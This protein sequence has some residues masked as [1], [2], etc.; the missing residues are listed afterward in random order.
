[1]PAI[2]LVAGFLL[3]TPYALLDMGTFLN[4]LRIQYGAQY[5]GHI[6]M[7]RAGATALRMLFDMATKEGPG[8]I[9]MGLIGIG[10][11]WVRFRRAWWVVVPLLVVYLLE[12]S[13]WRVYADRY[14][15]PSLPLM[16]VLASLA[17]DAIVGRI[18]IRPVRFLVATVLLALV[19]VP[20]AVVS[21]KQASELTLPDTRTLALQ[22][23]EQNIP[24]SSAILLELGGPQPADKN[25]PHHREPAYGI[26][27]LPPRFSDAS[28]GLDPSTALEL[29]EPEYVITS[30]NY[31]ARYEDSYTR[32]R[33][34]EIA[35][36]WGRYYATLDSQ[37]DVVYEIAP[38]SGAAGSRRVGP[39]IR[40]YR[41]RGPR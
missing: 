38:T 19:V 41:R 2:V 28:Q 5:Q 10:I 40:I 8:L 35:D 3:G 33:F 11:A 4:H 16:A 18:R 15:L 9:A 12:I 7:E 20:P 39:E 22:W 13:R 36:A 34:P 26:V 25:A 27:V 24:P 23:V 6:G 37:W 29:I 17:W 1:M 14:L 32:S 30:S 21:L 31:R